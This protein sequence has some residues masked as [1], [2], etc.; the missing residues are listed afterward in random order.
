MFK[1]ST[2]VPFQYKD[3]L[4]FIST[5]WLC[6]VA[7][8][9]PDDR[10]QITESVLWFYDR[11]V[12]KLDEPKLGKIEQRHFYENDLYSWNYSF[13][14]QLP[15][16]LI[17]KTLAAYILKMYTGT[18]YKEA[19]NKQLAKIAK[20]FGKLEFTSSEASCPITPI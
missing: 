18:C 14:I 20:A 19:I 13:D 10:E 3:E 7:C 15:E 2:D 16:M 17:G 11:R 5:E 4:H 1:A 9:S 6:K 8:L 12:L